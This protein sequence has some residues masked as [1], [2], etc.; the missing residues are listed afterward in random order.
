MRRQDKIENHKERHALHEHKRQLESERGWAGQ[1]GQ[2]P[3]TEE[4]ENYL[5][6]APSEKDAP[7]DQGGS[8]P[9]SKRAR[10]E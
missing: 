1:H 8:S 7:D 3:E 6:E 9:N 2:H 4:E 10:T 5:P